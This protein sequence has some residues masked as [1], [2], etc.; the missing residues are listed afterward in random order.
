MIGYSKLYKYCRKGEE[1]RIENYEEAE[2][3]PNET[4]V[5]HHRLELTL[6]N[7]YAHTQDDLKR[8]GMFYHRPYY[9]LIFMKSTD[10]KSLHAKANNPGKNKSEITRNRLS[11]S[12]KGS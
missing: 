8:L 7:E 5:I 6:D 12:K 4:W 1:S 11:N 10:H 3:D 9:E 2:N